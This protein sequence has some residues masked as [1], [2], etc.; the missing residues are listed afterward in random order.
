VLRQGGRR[1]EG[2][3]DARGGQA[4]ARLRREERPRQLAPPPQ[5]RRAQ[6]LRQEL[7]PPVDQLPPPGHQARPLHRR[8]GEA[9]HPPPLNP[10]KQVSRFLLRSTYL[11][12]SLIA[13]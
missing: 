12:A 13:P 1:E 6:P 2:P 5:A 8:G 4:A 11:E 9:H 10:R 3:V 7:P